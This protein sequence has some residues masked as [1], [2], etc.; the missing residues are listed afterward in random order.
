MLTNREFKCY[1]SQFN[2]KF[3]PDEPLTE[4]NLYDIGRVQVLGNFDDSTRQHFEIVLKGTATQ[5][6]DRT[7]NGECMEDRIIFSAELE[8]IGRK[9]INALKSAINYFD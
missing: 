9:W 7:S 8:S 2:A 5:K 4:I 1:K 6:T 3:H